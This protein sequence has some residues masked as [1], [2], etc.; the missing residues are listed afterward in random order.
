MREI[1]PHSHKRNQACPHLGRAY[2]LHSCERIDSVVY[3]AQCG[4]LLQQLEKLMKTPTQK[5]V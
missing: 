4:L 1:P 3:D 2:G 5:G